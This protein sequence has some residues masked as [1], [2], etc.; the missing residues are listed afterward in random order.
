MPTGNVIKGRF[1]KLGDQPNAHSFDLDQNLVC[2]H[3]VVANS[4]HHEYDSASGWV[5]RKNIE[6]R[7]SRFNYES[8]SAM[9]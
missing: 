2:H 7:M 5:I 1:G 4:E 9:H 3:S 6:T 8:L